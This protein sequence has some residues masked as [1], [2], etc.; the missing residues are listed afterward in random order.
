MSN[1][2]KKNITNFKEDEKESSLDF[3]ELIHAIIDYYASTTEQ[4]ETDS[5]EAWK[6][7]TE[8]EVQK[9]VP[10][11]LDEAIKKA[12]VVQIKKFHK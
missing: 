11:D 5:A 3:V 7:G 10:E 6:K 2:T 8:Y 1:S 4:E 9:I 12:F